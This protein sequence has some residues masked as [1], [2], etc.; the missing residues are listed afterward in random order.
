M[1]KHPF[2]FYFL[3]IALIGALSFS[4]KFNPNMQTPGESYLQGEWQQDSIPKQKQLV[5]YS[6][7]H[8][9]FSCDSF[10]VSIS[11]FSKVNTGADSCMNSGHW[12]EYCR[13]TYDQKNDT[14][15]LKGQFCNADMSLKDDKGCFR[16]GDY[17]EFFK[18]SKKADSLVQFASTTN[19]I[20]V[21]A[22][23]IKK[24]TCTPKPL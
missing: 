17:E 23:L 4:C 15:H 21:N 14:L 2:A 12:T 20:P 16:S 13:G 3:F 1:Q 8:L 10:F 9:K 22:R 6:L 5:T 18:V 19:I 24:T 11:S 7:Y